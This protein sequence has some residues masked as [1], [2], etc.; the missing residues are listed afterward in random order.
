VIDIGTIWLFES[1][2]SGEPIYGSVLK[3]LLEFNECG[4]RKESELNSSLFETAVTKFFKVGKR[5]GDSVCLAQGVSWA[6]TLEST[7]AAALDHE[8]AVLSIYQRMN[9]RYSPAVVKFWRRS[10]VDQVNPVLGF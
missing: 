9:L 2:G 3:L 4:E 1:S 6:I 8:F 5:G 10:L 7:Q